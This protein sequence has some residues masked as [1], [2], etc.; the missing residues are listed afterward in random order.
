MTERKAK[1]RGKSRMRSENADAVR[2]LRKIGAI[3]ASHPLLDKA[4]DDISEQEA[5]NLLCVSRPYLAGMID[6]GELPARMVGD[7]RRLPLKD[8][9]A[10][11]EA[12]K[13]KRFAA[14]DEL[15]ALDQEMGL[16]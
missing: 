15:S 12:N 1:P 13:A 11:R 8:V 7:Q 5:A 14:L 4:S 2:G 3:S 9:L 6:K 10:Y 16:E